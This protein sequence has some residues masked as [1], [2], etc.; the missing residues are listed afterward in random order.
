MIKKRF[1]RFNDYIL[2]IIASLILTISTQLIAYPF[3]SR[4]LNSEEYGNMLLFMGLINATAV[5]FGTPLNNTRLLLQDKYRNVTE[6]NG[7]F[8]I[9]FLYAIV[10][11]SIIIALITFVMDTEFT[12]NVIFYMAISFFI[13]FRSY[14]SVEYRLIINYMKILKVSC[15]CFVGYT[16]GIFFSYMTKQWMF[17]FF[18]GELFGFLYIIKGS[19]LIKEGMFKTEYYHIAKSKCN[20]I[21]LSSVI[22]SF[23]S[24]L[25]RFFI[26]PVLGSTNVAIYNVSSFIGKTAGIVMTPITGVMLT[27]YAKENKLN[28]KVF[29]KRIILFAAFS[30]LFY[31]FSVIIGKPITRL[32]YPDYVDIAMK[33]MYIANLSSILLILSNTIQPTLLRYC[34]TIWQPIIQGSYILLYLIF[35]FLGMKINGLYGFCVSNLIVNALKN[36]QMIIIVHLSISKRK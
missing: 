16:I 9:L 13:L 5:S 15:F 18:M 36:I 25:D 22:T 14:Y 17:T 28:L 30:S 24:Y 2:N 32:L 31:L 27:Y 21:L 4:L 6:K 34:N 19:T 8:N 12:Y 20:M 1:S 29:Y 10:F 23:S 3:L 7:D 11:N 35:G 26:Y 33:Y